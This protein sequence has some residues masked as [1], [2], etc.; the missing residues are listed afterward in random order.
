MTDT[1]T[2]EVGYG[3]P[4]LAHQFQKGRS[5]NPSGRPKG[6]RSVSAV[7]ASAL[8]ERVT[9]NVNGKRRSITKLEAAFTQLA[10]KAAGGD[11][12]AAKLIID[13]FHQSET[14]DEARA[15]GTPI[16]AEERRATDAAILE[17]LRATAL[18]ILPEDTHD[19]PV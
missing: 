19:Q 9:V 16:G 3:L 12:H 6:A 5:G 4:P 2:P 17:T 7:I 1:Q 13:L 8:S 14:R 15:A 11:R 18:N 10:N